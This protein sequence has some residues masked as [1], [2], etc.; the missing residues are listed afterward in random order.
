MS[1]SVR[2]YGLACQAPVSMGFSRQEYWTG[3]LCRPP[4]DL[5]DPGIKLASLLSPALADGLFT[6][7]ATWEAPIYKALYKKPP[8]YANGNIYTLFCSL[9]LTLYSSDLLSI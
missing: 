2:P 8:F 1:D 9:L 7:I 4:G 5:P 6:T 3:L